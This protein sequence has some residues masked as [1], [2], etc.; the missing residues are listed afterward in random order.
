[1]QRQALPLLH[2]E[3]PYVGTGLE[4][5]IAKDSGEALVADK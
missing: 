3:S 1:M 2:P 4:A 5:K